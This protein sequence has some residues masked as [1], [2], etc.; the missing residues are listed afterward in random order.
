MKSVVLA[1]LLARSVWSDLYHVKAAAAAAT[2]TQNL[3][4]LSRTQV[5]ASLIAIA[6]NAEY[7]KLYN[8]QCVESLIW[9]AQ[10][11]KAIRF[12][13]SLSKTSGQAAT[14]KGNTNQLQQA[15]QKTVVEGERQHAHS[16][17]FSAVHSSKSNEYQATA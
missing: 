12:A 5:C 16:G 9:Y 1:A 4:Q 8:V 13:D 14:S 11:R 15:G 3:Q 2:K 7:T 17:E 10:C 6:A